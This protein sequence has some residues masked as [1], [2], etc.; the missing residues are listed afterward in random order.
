MRNEERHSADIDILYSSDS[1]E[2]VCR[3]TV[4]N[5][6]AN[7]LCFIA[8]SP[9]VE[10]QSITIKNELPNGCTSA[11]VRWVKPLGDDYYMA[12]LTAQ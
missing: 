10:E 5:Y 3:G 9:C 4:V 2:E 8:G 6:G 11:S 7:G 12:G 1:S